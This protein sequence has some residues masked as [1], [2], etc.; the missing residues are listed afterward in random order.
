MSEYD[1]IPEI[2]DYIA[3]GAIGCR[4]CG[5]SFERVVR[6]DGT[7]EKCE[8]CGDEQYNL[9]A[10]NCDENG[11]LKSDKTVREADN[12]GVITFLLLRDAAFWK[13]TP[14]SQEQ[15]VYKAARDSAVAE[16]RLRLKSH[17]N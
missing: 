13:A 11:V 4:M 12:E 3:D 15:A 1:G 10:A 6:S 8:D 9:Y 7:V 2:Q 17:S 14:G 5:D 16:L